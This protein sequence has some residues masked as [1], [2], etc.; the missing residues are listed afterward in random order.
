VGRIPLKIL[1]FVGMIDLLMA[2]KTEQHGPHRA[3]PEALCAVC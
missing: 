2:G 1:L 3:A